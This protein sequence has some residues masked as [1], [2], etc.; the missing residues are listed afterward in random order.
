MQ[1]FLHTSDGLTLE[2]FDGNDTIAD[3]ASAAGLGD[4]TGWLEDAGAAR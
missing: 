1:I 2:N 4:T 3:A